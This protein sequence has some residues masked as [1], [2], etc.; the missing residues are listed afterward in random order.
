MFVLTEQELDNVVSQS[1]IPSR[2]YFGGALPYGF[3]EQGVYMV[4]ALLRSDFAID[5]SIEIMRTFV[6]LSQFASHYNALAKKILEVE[7]KS[8]KQ[9]RELTQAIHELIEE[10]NAAPMRQIGFVK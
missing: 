10:A 5:V 8:D 9:Y 2:Q 1:V 7:R 4:A 6:K 3:T